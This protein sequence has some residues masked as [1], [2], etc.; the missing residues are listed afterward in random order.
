MYRS[1]RTVR[2]TENTL[3]KNIAVG[4]ATMKNKISK[5]YTCIVIRITPDFLIETYDCLTSHT[6]IKRDPLV[7][8]LWTDEQQ[9]WMNEEQTESVKIAVENKFQLIQGP[10]GKS[11]TTMTVITF[12]N[13][14]SL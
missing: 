4:E 1:L 10:P 12:Y 3:C 9:Q 11:N 2:Y 14:I 8:K 5:Y 6:L 7:V 13:V